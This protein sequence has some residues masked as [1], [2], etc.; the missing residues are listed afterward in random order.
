MRVQ[1]N[2]GI[3]DAN[4]SA[5]RNK[6]DFMVLDVIIEADNTRMHHQTSLYRVTPTGVT[7]ASFCA[8]FSVMSLWTWLTA[9]DTKLSHTF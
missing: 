2:E 8:L 6:L 7:R 1:I 3:G 9:I 4:I 5:M